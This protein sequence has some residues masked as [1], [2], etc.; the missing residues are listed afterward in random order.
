[1]IITEVKVNICK[2]SNA[3]KILFKTIMTK[4]IV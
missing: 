1:M 2:N 4:Y 3:L